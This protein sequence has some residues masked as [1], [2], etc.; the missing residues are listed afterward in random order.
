M[1]LTCAAT[2]N[3]TGT[4]NV[5]CGGSAVKAYTCSSTMSVVPVKKAAALT[6]DAAKVGPTAL[7]AGGTAGSNSVNIKCPVA[8]T[9]WV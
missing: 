1:Y 5:T 3:V 6:G 2:M 7:K 9:A 4:V 8:G